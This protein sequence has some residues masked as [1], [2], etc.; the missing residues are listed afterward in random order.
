MRSI[1]VDD[2]GTVSRK[3]FCKQPEGMADIVNI[4]KEIQMIGIHIQDDTDF[5]E[6]A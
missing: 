6:K 2:Q 3:F 1:T 5:R 4:L